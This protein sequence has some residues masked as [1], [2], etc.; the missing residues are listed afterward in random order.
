MMPDINAPSA[1]QRRLGEPFVLVYSKAHEM[2][3]T[4]L[5]VDRERVQVLTLAR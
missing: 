1:L 5:K 3:G 2:S 4:L